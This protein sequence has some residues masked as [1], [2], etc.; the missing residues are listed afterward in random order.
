[1]R[2][3]CEEQERNACNTGESPD[4]WTEIE[5]LGEEKTGT[6]QWGARGLKEGRRTGGPDEEGSSCHT[7]RQS[8]WGPRS[9][10][11]G[12]EAYGNRRGTEYPYHR[13]DV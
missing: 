3:A 4:G 1:M 8:S 13:R 9:R 7:S 12:R 5:R 10:I 6:R 2:V 11:D